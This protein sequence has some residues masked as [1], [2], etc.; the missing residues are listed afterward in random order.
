M[1]LERIHRLYAEEKKSKRRG[2]GGGVAHSRPLRKGITASSKRRENEARS[3]D[4][5]SKV[6]F[7]LGFYGVS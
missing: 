1:E 5:S 3:L 7:I 2:G 6:S 4:D